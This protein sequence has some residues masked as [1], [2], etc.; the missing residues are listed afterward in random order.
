MSDSNIKVIKSI[1]IIL[2]NSIIKRYPKYIYSINVEDDTEKD[3]QNLVNFIT[4][5]NQ[6]QKLTKSFEYIL[7]ILNQGTNQEKLLWNSRIESDILYL[8]LRELNCESK[9]RLEA[10]K[11]FEQMNSKISLAVAIIYLNFLLSISLCSLFDNISIPKI[12]LEYFKQ[13]QLP[14]VSKSKSISSVKTEE[15]STSVHNLQMCIIYCLKLLRSILEEEVKSLA[16]IDIYT[17]HSI[18]DKIVFQLLELAIPS[19]FVTLIFVERNSEGGPINTICLYLVNEL[20]KTLVNIEVKGLENSLNWVS[21]INFAN[22]TCYSD[23]RYAPLFHKLLGYLA[24]HNKKKIEDPLVQSALQF[25]YSAFGPG[26]SSYEA[27]INGEQDITMFS[28]EELDF[29]IFTYDYEYLYQTDSSSRSNNL[30]HSSSDMSMS[31]SDK[32]G[33]TSTPQKQ[34]YVTNSA[35]QQSIHV[36]QFGKP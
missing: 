24:Y 26:N 1:K 12:A 22:D 7:E 15:A 10:Y 28:N 17:P 16:F 19:L 2:F 23:L 29:D 9:I 13:F 32:L 3:K 30:D 34:N 25:F 33:M 31:Q 11:C 18:H 4:T 8:Y 6:K 35:R 5:L 14:P 36:D 20:F 21:I 27:W